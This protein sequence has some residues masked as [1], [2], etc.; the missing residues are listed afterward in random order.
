VAVS[1]EVAGVGGVGI[2]TA[3]DGESCFREVVAGYDVDGSFC[4]LRGGRGPC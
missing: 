3:V 1:L 4:C 2:G